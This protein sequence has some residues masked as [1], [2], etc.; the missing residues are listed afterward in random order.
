MIPAYIEWMDALPLLPNDKVNRKELPR[1]TRT[2]KHK[3]TISRKPETE[4]E[5]IMAD[6][7]EEMLDIDDIETDDMFFDLGGHSLL[8]LK[9]VDRFARETNI[10]I[11]PV[12]LINQTLR[13]LAASADA[14][15]KV[16][17][18][19]RDKTA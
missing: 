1:P 15:A 14:A 5:I 10:R 19:D 11:S 4:M 7:W 3:K 2:Q 8:T 17:G 12:G 13:Q 16:S 18:K 9:V 6:I